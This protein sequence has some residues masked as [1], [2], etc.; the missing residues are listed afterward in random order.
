M[1][2][3]ATKIKLQFNLTGQVLQ[4]LWQCFERISVCSCEPMSCP[5]CPTASWCEWGRTK[6]G[7]GGGLASPYTSPN[8]GI[9]VGPDAGVL[10]VV[11]RPSKQRLRAA[12]SGR[13]HSGWRA[14]ASLRPHLLTSRSLPS[15]PGRAIWCSEGRVSIKPDSLK[16]TNG[17][18]LFGCVC[19]VCADRK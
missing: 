8:S 7:G 12:E 10:I 15:K 6:R 2:R 16:R 9:T 18:T 1:G 17:W 19:R 5:G 14:A 11:D 4:I 3:H 13:C